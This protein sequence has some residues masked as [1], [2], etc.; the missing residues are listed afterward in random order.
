MNSL[1]SKLALTCAGIYGGALYVNYTMP[2][3]KVVVSQ[4]MDSMVHVRLYNE[5]GTMRINDVCYMKNGEKYRT[6]LYNEHYAINEDGMNFVPALVW[7]DGNRTLIEC[8]PKTERSRSMKIIQ[9]LKKNQIYV[10]YVPIDLPFI[11]KNT[12]ISKTLD[13]FG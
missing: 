3:P 4:D 7:R 13:I 5:G 10:E 1:A 9:P 8:T 2:D 11:G 12:T 6:L